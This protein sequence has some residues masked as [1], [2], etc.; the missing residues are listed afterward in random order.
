MSSS[1]I[2]SVIFNTK[3]AA[4]TSVATI[5]AGFA[6]FLNLIPNTIGVV[7]SILGVILTTVLIITH[8][9][10]MYRDKDQSERDAEKD[11]L[12]IEILKRQL[13]E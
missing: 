7:A 10:K 3:I 11:K 6:S 2:D 9:K 1:L 8:I 5:T 12:E 13:K 4:T